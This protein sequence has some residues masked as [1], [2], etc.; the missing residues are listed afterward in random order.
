MRYTSIK[1]SKGRERL[2]NSLPDIKKGITAFIGSG[3]KTSLIHA[4]CERLSV[5]N[6]V[7]FCTTTHI[8]P[9]ESFFVIENPT[10]EQIRSELNLHNCICIGNRN[11]DGKFSA[12][13]VDIPTLALLADYVLVEADGS[14]RLPIKAHAQHEPVI[15]QDCNQT[16]LVIGASGIGERI[17]QKVHRPEIYCSIAQCGADELI[18]CEN[19][20]AVINKENL[21]DTIFVNQIDNNELEYIPKKIETLT[22][23][24][25]Y[26]GSLMYKKF[27]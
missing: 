23:R 21:C 13:D 1:T 19:V 26:Y 7:I 24:P 6:K 20:S 16:V 3:G 4:F 10:V 25:V 14:R 15:P 22:K 8:F 17:S 5:N 2:K 18:T 9:S 27:I 11:L 12:P